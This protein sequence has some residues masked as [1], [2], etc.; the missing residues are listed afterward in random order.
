MATAG[1]DGDDATEFINSLKEM[2]GLFPELDPPNSTWLKMTRKDQA[3]G[4][5][6]PMGKVCISIELV[7]EDIVANDPV[8]FG[9]GEPNHSPFCPPP[10]GRYYY[11]LF[12]K[13][14]LRPF[15]TDFFC[16]GLALEC[17]R[18]KLHA[19]DLEFV[20]FY[21][22]TI[23]KFLLEPHLE[24]ITVISITKYRFQYHS[25]T[26]SSPS[27]YWCTYTQA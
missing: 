10:V 3:T 14:T 9:R 26:Y 4:K 11:A 25:T 13:I 17:N 27:E 7:P 16:A 23:P 20:Y 18:F 24:S 22:Y 6:E 2:S 12:F 21:F 5:I 1:G 15:L 19:V 8:G